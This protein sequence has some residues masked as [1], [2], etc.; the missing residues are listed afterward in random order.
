MDLAP[1][2]SLNARN[3]PI[4]ASTAPMSTTDRCAACDRVSANLK[5]CTACKMVK[6]CGVECQ[7]NH[8]SAHREVC[9]RRTEEL[10]FQEPPAPEDCPVCF[11][12]LPDRDHKYFPCCGKTV[13]LG[14]CVQLHEHH[15]KICPHCRAPVGTPEEEFGKL[16]RRADGGDAIAIGLMGLLYE[17]GDRVEQNMEMAIQLYS[18][19]ARLGRPEC[20]YRL[21]IMFKQGQGVE[22]D[23]NK[24][25]Y[26]MQQSAILGNVGARLILG[27]LDWE[28]HKRSQAMKHLRI[29]VANGSKDALD[30]IKELFQLNWV[31]RDEYDNAKLAY[32]DY[33]VRVGSPERDRAA[34]LMDQRRIELGKRRVG[35]NSILPI[36]D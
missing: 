24:Y 12:M 20:H 32:R 27:A 23:R 19:A 26:H 4:M 2:P 29:A 18:R 21:G 17:K 10:L 5:T 22:Q 7:R 9:E 30:M 6:Y 28:R 34:E 25:Y 14:C 13:C 31:G 15:Y 11:Y 36:A 35:R 16:Q 3:T 33:T 1:Q 8:R